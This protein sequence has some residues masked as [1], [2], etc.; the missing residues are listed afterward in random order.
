LCGWEVVQIQSDR[1]VFDTYDMLATAF[2]SFFAY[3]AFRWHASGFEVRS[4]EAARHGE[5]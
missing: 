5:A 4:Y 2:G 3:L 1:F